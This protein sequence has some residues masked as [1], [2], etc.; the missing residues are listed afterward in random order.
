MHQ[1]TLHIIHHHETQMRHT[2][3]NLHTSYND[4]PHHTPHAA[5][6]TAAASTTTPGHSATRA[7]AE[8]AP[9]SATKTIARHNVIQTAERPNIG[10]SAAA[11]HQGSS[12]QLTIACILKTM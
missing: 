8:R 6:A 11:I 3:G 2:S 10:S 1:T 7:T 5:A 12:S 9:L 4:M